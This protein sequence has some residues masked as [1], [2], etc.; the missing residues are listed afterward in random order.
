[1]KLQRLQSRSNYVQFPFVILPRMPPPPTPF[2]VCST[3]VYFPRVSGPSISM[4]TF[5]LLAPGLPI[6]VFARSNVG[7]V[8]SIPHD[9][10]G[11]FN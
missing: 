7:I 10:I 9:V 1:M 11:F 3:S 4:L 8:G 5:S 2:T 6:T